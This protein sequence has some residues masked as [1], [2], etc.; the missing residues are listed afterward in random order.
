MQDLMQPEALGFTWPNHYVLEH[1][2]SVMPS[3][4]AH[5]PHLAVMYTVQH[6]TQ[7]ILPQNMGKNPRYEV[8]Q[9][10]RETLYLAITKLVQSSLGQACS[11]CT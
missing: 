8:F 3:V 7:K 5:V 4:H 10:Y 9:S 6:R 2:S 11:H 1:I